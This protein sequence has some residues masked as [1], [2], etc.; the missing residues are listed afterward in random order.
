MQPR[1]K[2]GVTKAVIL[3]AGEGTRMR[4]LTYTRPKVMLPIANKPILEHVLN[5]MQQAGIREFIFIVGYHD[6][7]IRNYFGGG[8]KWGVSIQ[9]CNQKEHLGTADALRN[10]EGLIS[11]NFLMANGDAIISHQDIR[12]L[13]DRTGNVLS[14]IELQDVSGLGVIEIKA[15]KISRICEKMQNPPSHLANAGLYLFT[16]AIFEAI[17]RTD[18]SPRGEY[19]ITDSIQLLI[20]SGQAVSY[21]EIPD[22]LDFSYPWNLLTANEKIMGKLEPHTYG[23]VESNVVM[24]GS[25]SV[26]KGTTVKSGSYIIGPVIIGQNCEIGPNCYIRP[27]TVIADNCHVGAAVEVKNSIV[28]SGSKIPHLTYVGDSIIGENCNLGAGTKIANLRLDKQNVRIDGIDTK[29]RKLGAIIGDKVETGI[30]SSIN[31]GTM[32]GNNTSIGP[33]ALVYGIIPPGSKIL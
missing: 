7:Q 22:W 5:E 31:L 6:E 19:E 17:K 24:K 30:N 27:S 12:L 28:M 11:E 23:E 25:V 3:A 9:Y 2:K 4:P 1:M 29:K 8:E 18:K 20:D 13:T 14:V 32:I 33:G 21:Q 26:G 10:A 15:G 16:A